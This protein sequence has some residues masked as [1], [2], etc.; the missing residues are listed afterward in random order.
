MLVDRA[1]IYVKAGDGGNGS[2]S[3]RREKYVP[4]GGPDG[5]DGGRGGNVSLRVMPN[6]TSLLPFRYAQRFEAERGGPGRK[7]Q[8]HGK[9]GTDLVID[10]PPGTVVWDDESDELLADLTEPGE[11]VTIAK[12]GRGGLGNVHLK[13]STRHAPRLTELREPG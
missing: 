7:Q 3:F 6:L 2:A 8:Q 11:E 10:V 9:A 5:G 1:R 4:R 13:S 12:G